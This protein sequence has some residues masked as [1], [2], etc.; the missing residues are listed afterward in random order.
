MAVSNKVLDDKLRS[1]YLEIVKSCLADKGEE[2]LITGTSEFAIPCVDEE[3]NDKFAVFSVK[4][5]TGSR[6]G[7]AYDGYSMAEDYKMKAEA[8]AEKAKAAAEKKAKKIERD[9]AKRE[10]LAKAKAEREVKGE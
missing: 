4:I 3:G 5:P 1:K 9:K 6:E 2:I 7:D 8:K 10:Q